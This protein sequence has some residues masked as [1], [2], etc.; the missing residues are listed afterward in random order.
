MALY[1]GWQGT[2]PRAPYAPEQC[3]WIG[4]ESEGNTGPCENSRAVYGVPS[5]LLRFVL[6]LYGPRYETASL[7]GDAQ[8]M[9]VL[10]GSP[11]RGLA[12]L[13]D[14]TGADREELLVTFAAAMWA[15]DRP[16]LGDWILSWN[17]YDIFQNVTPGARLQPYTS[18]AAEPTLDVSVRAASNAY[19]EW[20]PPLLH[21][22][23][24]LRIRDPG[25]ASALPRDMVLWVLRVQ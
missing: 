16:G 3:S 17:L 14:A 21:A 25:D 4:R 13:E 11:Q 20:S 2:A 6:D 7:L 24:S 19:L 1:F 8:L 15:D 5:T 23:T 22:P 10:T 12:A 18:L 9:R